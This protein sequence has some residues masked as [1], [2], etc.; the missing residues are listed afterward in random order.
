MFQITVEVAT[1]DMTEVI[2]RT[3]TIS[4]EDN[5]MINATMMTAVAMELLAAKM[6]ITMKMTTTITIKTDIVVTVDVVVITTT[7]KG[8]MGMVIIDLVT[9][10]ELNT[11][12][13]DH[14]ITAEHLMQLQEIIINLKAPMKCCRLMWFFLCFTEIYNC[15]CSC[16]LLSLV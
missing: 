7:L 9:Y 6:H 15:I 10:R 11:S 2:M 8:N 13:V 12:T 14:I 5:V 1:T 16:F 4:S 3:M